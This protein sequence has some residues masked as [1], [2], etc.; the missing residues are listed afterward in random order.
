MVQAII[1][2]KKCYGFSYVELPLL[3]A[4]VHLQNTGDRLKFVKYFDH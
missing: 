3:R 4:F 1:E 2:S